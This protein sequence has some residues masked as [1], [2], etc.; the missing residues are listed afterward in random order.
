M[1]SKNKK[2]LFIHLPKTGGNSVQ[3]KLRLYS[4]DKIVRITEIQDGVE[5]FEVRN[6]FTGLTKHSSY[7]DYER[8]LPPDLM[9]SLFVFTTIRNPWERMISFYFSPHRKI[10]T[11]NRGEFVSL[12]TQ[13]KTLPELLGSQRSDM[14]L[15]W[16]DNANFI[17]KFES[18]D[19]DFQIVCEK[20]GLKYNTLNVRNKS[21]RDDYKT[22]YDDELVE[23]VRQKFHEEI[24]FGKYEF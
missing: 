13:V 22:Y 9:Q 3:E 5:R 11:W 23:I 12:L 2:F 1:L 10:S 21:E 18:L 14:N 17:M 7:A 19:N 20:L 6:E 4:E 15:H 8:L 16:S 24:D